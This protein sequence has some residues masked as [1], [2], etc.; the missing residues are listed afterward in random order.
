MKKNLLTITALCVASCLCAA[1]YERN[2]TTGYYRYTGPELDEIIAVDFGQLSAQDTCYTENTLH[3]ASRILVFQQLGLYKFCYYASRQLGDEVY[4]PILWNNNTSSNGKNNEV[5]VPYRPTI[6][7]PVFKN[8]IHQVI[9]SGWCLSS[10]SLYAQA[11]T[12]SGEWQASNTLDTKAKSYVNL[13]KNAYTTDT[14]TFTRQDISQVSL[15]R[16]GGGYLFVHRI[17]IIPNGHESDVVPVSSLVLN[18]HSLDLDPGKSV[19]LTATIAPF[20]ATD[21]TIQWHSTNPTCASVSNQGLV[22]GLTDGT[23]LIIA[24]AGDKSDTCV[25]TV[26]DLP[27]QEILLMRE[28]LRR[29]VFLGPLDY[30][31]NDPL[32]QAHISK[33]VQDATTYQNSLEKNPTTYLWSDYSQL[34]GDATNTCKHVEYSLMRLRTMALAWAYPSST[35]YHDAS[36]LSDIR[37]SLDFMYSYALNE[38]TPAIGNWWEWR[39]GSPQ[40]YAAIVSILYEELSA[41]QIEHYYITFSSLVRDCA[42]AASLT[43]ANQADVCRNLLYMGILTGRAD[44][45]R[46]AMLYAKPAFVDAT[47]LAT[48]K[49]AQALFEKMIIEQGDYHNYN[50]VMK[51]EGFY[52]DGTFIQHTALPYIGTYGASMIN[53]SAQMQLALAGT[54]LFSAP[55]YF[56]DIT[57]RW[58]EKA[59][60][61]AIY[62]GEMMRMF[63]G[64]SMNSS[65]NPHTSARNIGLDIFLSREL[66]PDLTTRQRIVNVCKT[67]YTDNAYYSGIYDGMDPI[68]DKPHIDAM[69]AAADEDA[70][71][72]EFNL[73]LAAGDRVIHETSKYRLG[74]AMSSNRIGKFEGFTGNNMSGWYTGDGMIYIYTPNS[75]SHWVSFFNSCNYYR[76]PGTTVDRITRAADGASMSLFDSPVNAQSWVGGISLQGRYGAAG[77][78][79]VGAKSD[80][81]AKKSWFMFTDEVYCLGA[82][83]SM[84]ENRRVETIVEQRAVN[85]NWWVDGEAGT[86]KLSYDIAYTNPQYA[87]I[88]GVGGYYFPEP[89]KLTT[90]IESNKNRTLYFDHGKAPQN[91]S[92]AYVLLPQMTLAETQ[93]YVNHA[94]VKILDNT[95]TLQGVYHTELDIWAINFYTA[96]HCDAIS[97]N[98]PASL[99]CRHSENGDTLYLAVAEPTW[100][101]GEQIITLDGEYTLI[102]AT[103]QDKVSVTTTVDHKTQ[104]TINSKDRMGM[105][106]QLV[107]KTIHAMTRPA[108]ITSITTP[109]FDSQR[110]YKTMENGQIIIYKGIDRYS[111]LGDKL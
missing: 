15:N 92:Y 51:K 71:P 68:I 5:T 60:F 61:P 91:A 46:N 84:S 56:Y 19:Q 101:C 75:R 73:V 107:L 44:D 105:G 34:V 62:K 10:G 54:T 106:E 57:Q 81:V 76:M 37:R 11:R 41:E 45:I 23:A 42:K 3:D 55:S 48:R 50:G 100:K 88:D 21:R 40:V 74:I 17:Q 9:I 47:S 82:G 80:L 111:V 69:I 86:T 22:E 24:S 39:I 49:N 67:W 16:T 63:M 70:R 27:G 38:N 26:S 96:G 33:I 79:H 20:N 110:V 28:N 98:A 14:L 85:G 53:F 31:R 104:I 29:E 97:S 90:Y 2:T 58:I 4:A 72:D 35:R 30:N 102:S 59:Y 109:D 89:C 64:R 32:I 78:S 83:I 66:V 8:G 6:Y 87:Y 99:M 52:E 103:P 65:H 43:Y 1:L 25:V 93:A 13:N 77:M 12:Q 108:I 36:L 95:D 94:P 18:Y 7:T